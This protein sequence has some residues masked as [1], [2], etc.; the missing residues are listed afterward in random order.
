[1]VAKAHFHIFGPQS[2]LQCTSVEDGLVGPTTWY[3]TKK[4]HLYFIIVER[5]LLQTCTA[6]KTK[7]FTHSSDLPVTKLQGHISSPLTNARGNQ[8]IRDL[9]TADNTCA[10]V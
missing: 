2:L 5:D 3:T 4:Y 7:I 8:K 10:I 1:M 6:A 9:N